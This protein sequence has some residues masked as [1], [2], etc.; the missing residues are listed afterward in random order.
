LFDIGW[1]EMAIIML[2][3]L[4]IIGP[5]DL[6]RVARTIGQW[7]RKG[8]MLAREFQ[9]SLE[10][11]AKEAE[12]DDVKREIDKI[13]RTDLKKAVEKTVDPKGELSKAFDVS[14]DES[15][16]APVVKTEAPEA[17]DKTAA[18]SPPAASANGR[19]KGGD[20]AAATSASGQAEAKAW[21]PD[22][23]KRAAAKKP[24]ARKPATK[25]SAKPRAAGSSKSSS[26]KKPPGAGKSSPKAR[27]AKA[28][29][30][31]K[32]ASGDPSS[33]EDGPAAMAAKS[34]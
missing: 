20:G 34:S 9:T 16:A 21:A 15:K 24:A 10:D 31:T 22:A 3:A 4:I 19:A 33:A 18:V 14:A 27:A 11:M 12:L 1:S 23:K 6:P 17:Q 29:P 30:K 7:V 32:A 8:R 13:G 5:K 2:L 26:T 25:S 28:A